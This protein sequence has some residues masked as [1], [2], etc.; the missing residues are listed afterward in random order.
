MARRK[1][2]FLDDGDSSEPSGS[3]NG[4]SFDPNEDPDHRAEREL[5]ENPYKRGK[6]RRVSGE[7]SEDEEEGFGG[8]AKMVPRKRSD[9]TK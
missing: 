8:R 5:W 4:D 1:R 6:R 2:Q 9:W 3:E 7:D